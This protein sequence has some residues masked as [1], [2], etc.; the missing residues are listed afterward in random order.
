MNGTWLPVCMSLEASGTC[1]PTQFRCPDHRCISPLY[2]CDGDKDCVDGSDEA[3]CGKWMAPL[4]LT[5]W[6]S[7]YLGVTVRHF[8]LSFS[9]LNCTSSQ[10][11]CADGS[12]CIN[13]RYRCDGVYDCKDNSDE[14]GCRKY[15]IQSVFQT[16][17]FFILVLDITV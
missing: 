10:F 15:H 3:G 14:A 12:A 5:V 16:Q 6:C 4:F 9:V 2:V 11:K 1:Q 13:S 8:S 7:V 17:G